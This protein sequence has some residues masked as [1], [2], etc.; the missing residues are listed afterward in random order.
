MPTNIGPIKRESSTGRRSN[1]HDL[2]E[3]AATHGMDAIAARISELHAAGNHL[4][5]DTIEY[6][7]RGTGVATELIDSDHIIRLTRQLTAALRDDAV[8]ETTALRLV[9]ALVARAAGSCRYGDKR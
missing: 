8:D 9:G 4:A 6:E 5:A 7:L 2:R 3:I 1:P